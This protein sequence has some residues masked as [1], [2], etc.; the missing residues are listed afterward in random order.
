MSILPGQVEIA[1]L[2][3]AIEEFGYTVQSAPVGAE[4]LED[5]ARHQEYVSLLRR[6]WV[7]TLL[8]V[9]TLVLAMGHEMFHFRGSNWIQ[10]LLSTPV[11]FCVLK[12]RSG[13]LATSDARGFLRGPRNIPHDLSSLLLTSAPCDVRL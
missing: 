8:S 9:P 3:H 13:E 11:M 4:D 2:H 6:L 1:N 5:K 12:C 10:L 7:A